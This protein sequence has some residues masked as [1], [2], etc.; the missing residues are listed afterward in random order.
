MEFQEAL[1]NN[2]LEAVRHLLLVNPAV[3]NKPDWEE[4]PLYTVAK[5]GNFPM[6][7]LLVEYSFASFDQRAED[8]KTM[9]H[10]A[11]IGG[12]L[13]MVR[14]VTE[15]MGFSPADG[16]RNGLTP[17]QMAHDAGQK[18][19]LDYFEAYLGFTYE[20]SYQNPI[21]RGMHPDPSVLRVGDDYYMAN[22]SFVM[23]PAIPISHSKDLVHWRTIGHAI[24]NPE[25]ARLTGLESGRGYWAPDISY[26]DGIFTVTATY[27]NNDSELLKRTQMVT[28]ASKPEG[29]YCEPVFIEE[30]G[31]DPSIFNDDDGRRYMLLNRGARIF[32][33]SPDA[34]KKVGEAKML[35]YGSDKRAPEGAHLLKKD[36]YYYLFQAE[37]GT[38]IN[39]K[40]TVSRSRELM[41]TYEPC[42][43]N[44]IMTQRDLKGYLQ[45]AGHG[46]PVMTQN[47][48]WY[49]TY[50]CTRMQGG[51]YSIL[52]RET[53]MDSITWTPDGW[54]LINRL[55]GPSA[56][57]AKPDL[58]EYIF[59][60]KEGLNPHE[61]VFLR[62]NGEC[63]P[64]IGEKDISI[65][66]SPGD[67]WEYEFRSF[68]FCRQDEFRFGM[69][70]E[71]DGNLGENEAGNEAG[72]VWYYDE[73]TFITCGLLYEEGKKA[74]I[75]IKEYLGKTEKELYR[76]EIAADNLKAVK[77]TTEADGTKR[78]F[79]FASVST[80]GKTEALQV[81]TGDD[82]EWF[83]TAYLS[84]EGY[85]LGKR[86]TGTMCGFY[87]RNGEK[88][89]KFRACFSECSKNSLFMRKSE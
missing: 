26:K 51:Q 9:L 74:Y 42:P 48:D 19:I 71:L 86:F 34:N 7:K 76:K 45:R 49:I 32:E 35:F 63:E 46:K 79:A 16:D 67:P 89:Q 37:G 38:G 53:A 68:I 40:I 66:S 29:P 22:S 55:K 54:P 82:G 69:T 81:C 12:N 80:E 28:H 18:E 44:P 27:R 73:Y 84:D 59:E 14:Y 13:E 1:K 15:R 5:S 64:I 23:F 39:H 72:I 25:W 3:V 20:G 60:E 21:I 52:G 17:L 30:D 50:L 2:D 36:G 87:G 33:L 70:A 88:T 85:P 43:Y 31:I 56:I 10:Y 4:F 75:V 61:W 6:L 41:G 83:D 77:L 47:G 78:K 57:A 24:T 11:T 62:T 8:G 58:P 65:L